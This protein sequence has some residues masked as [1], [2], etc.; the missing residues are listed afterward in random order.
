MDETAPTPLVYLVDDDS[1]YLLLIER[2]LLRNAPNVKIVKCRD[3][4]EALS[5]LSQP[6][7]HLPEFLILGMS[8]GRLHGL[9]FLRRIRSLEHAALLPVVVFSGYRHSAAVLSAYKAGANS[10]VAKPDKSDDLQQTVKCICD[11]WL[12]QNVPSPLTS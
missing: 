11:F 7:V 4:E 6:D 3:G 8:V 5:S 2:A 12:G 10:Y 1:D 9:D